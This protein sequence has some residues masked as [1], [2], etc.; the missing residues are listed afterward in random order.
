M[1][2][3]VIQI[4]SRFDPMSESAESRYDRVV[5][6]M[7]QLRAVGNRHRRLAS[8]LATQFVEND[9]GVAS[10]SPEQERAAPAQRRRRLDLLLRLDRELHAMDDEREGLGRELE[11]MN[12]A[13]DA[14][15]REAYGH[16]PDEELLDD[17]PPLTQS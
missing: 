6:R 16:T 5:R 3:E 2:A 8:E 15:A 12:E 14:W 7:N 1:S 9:P 13:I 10:G 17:R 4:R 11:A